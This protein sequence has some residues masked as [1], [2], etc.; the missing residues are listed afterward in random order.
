[1]DQPKLATKF[2]PAE[3]AS[4]STLDIQAQ[5]FFDAPL[6]R[7][8][9]DS[10]PDIVLI[11]NQQRQIVFANSALLKATGRPALDSLL[12]QRPGEALGCTHAFE[13]EGGCGT[14]E[15]CQTCGAVKAILSSLRGKETIQECHIIQQDGEALDLQVWSTP[16]TL[17]GQRF[18]IFAIKDISHEKRR[19]ALERVFFHDLLNV[20]TALRGYVSLLDMVTT[21]E[22]LNTMKKSIAELCEQLVEEINAQRELVA[23]ENNELTPHLEFID[24]LLFLTE[25]VEIYRSHT[26]AKERHFHIDSQAQ[27]IL[28]QTDATLLRRVIGNMVK[29]ALEAIEPGQVVTLGC[30]QVDEAVELWVHNPGTIPHEVQLQIFQRSFSTKGA[31]RGLG[32]YSMHLLS[33]RY[34]KGQVTFSSNPENGTTFKGRYPIT[35]Q[36]EQ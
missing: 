2:A 20:A 21:E 4:R 15:F 25:L 13:T 12:G 35:L 5:Q 31:G 27:S 8:I 28:F 29:N 30:R 16:L 6:L 1:M 19:Q 18:S 23:A 26:V 33:H 11:L 14:T 36:D 10:V 22:D 7:H 24:S 3:R 17:A 9:F 32:T 34:L